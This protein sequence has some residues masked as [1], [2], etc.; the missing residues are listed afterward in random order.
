MSEPPRYINLASSL[1][2]YDI[3]V[4]TISIDYNLEYAAS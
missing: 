3:V 2:V 4:F 1:Y